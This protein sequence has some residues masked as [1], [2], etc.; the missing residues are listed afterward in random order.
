MYFTVTFE[1]I[2]PFFRHEKGDGVTVEFEA[3]ISEGSPILQIYD[4]RQ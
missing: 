1:Y 2:V 3:K 4:Q